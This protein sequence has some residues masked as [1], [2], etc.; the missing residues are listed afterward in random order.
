MKEITIF[1]RYCETVSGKSQKTGNP[2]SFKKQSCYIDVGK[3]VLAETSM[4][5]DDNQ[6][7]LHIGVYMIKPE[8]IYVDRNQRVSINISPDTLELVRKLDD[9]KAS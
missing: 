3:P 4:I 6:E 8:A 7:P 5:L 2:Y 1:E 9:K